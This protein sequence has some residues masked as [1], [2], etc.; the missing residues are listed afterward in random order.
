[1]TRLLMLGITC[2][3]AFAQPSLPTAFG[4][5]FVG[6]L[7]SRYE[8]RMHLDR[9]DDRL[10]GRY[11]YMN[12]EESLLGLDGTIEGSGAFTLKEF[13][14]GK[15]TGSF[16]GVLTRDAAQGAV[17]LLKLTGSW[18]SAD[19][20]RTLP[21]ELVE[22]HLEVAGRA[23]VY[24]TAAVQE[25]DAKLGYSVAA[26]YPQFDGPAAIVETANA[27]IKA[28]VTKEVGEF[29]K[30]ARDWMR[31]RRAERGA[32]S[33][34]TETSDLNIGYEMLAADHGV[35]SLRFAQ[36]SYF[37]GTAHPSHDHTVFNYS[38]REGRTLTLADLFTTRSQYLKAIAAYCI[39]ELGLDDDRRNGARPT[40]ANYSL[41]NLTPAGLLITFSEY[42]VGAYVDGMPAVTIPYSELAA[43]VR[44]DGP[45]APF[46]K[47]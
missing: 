23:I 8:V 17:R 40:S 27:A 3:L 7:G 35:I 32:D 29:K 21:F 18:S 36:D 11:T 14:A 6:K 42:Q 19:G 1:M 45:A 43:F 26:G 15:Q 38:F 5:T 16:S 2:A 41:W 47:K 28:M 37:P 31:D 13:A 25:E 46:V 39:E 20:A 24:T 30:Q 22:E 44:K 10:S 34:P 9:K 33:D 4:K 12:V